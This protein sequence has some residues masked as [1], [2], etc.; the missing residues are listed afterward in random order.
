MGGIPADLLIYI[1]VAAALVLWLRNTLGTRHG[2]ER[3]RPNPFTAKPEQE[4]QEEG[5]KG[6]TRMPPMKSPAPI[7]LSDEPAEAALFEGLSIDRGPAEEGLR[8]ICRADRKFRPADFVEKAKDA[9]TI[10]VESFAAGD[11]DILSELLSP[12]VYKSFAAAIDAREE[13]GETVETE[14]HSIPAID[15]AEAGITGNQAFITL[16]I[17]A[18]ETAVIRKGKKII[19]GDPDR[20]TTMTD[21]WTFGRALKTKDPTWRVIRTRDGE[22]EPHKTPLPDAS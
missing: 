22:P 11:K 7:M 14:I 2:D 19:S 18:E 4:K 21:L 3:E 8:A 5:K 16:R 12:S 13:T 15:I 17:I 6:E 20:I 1:I 9:F 10:I